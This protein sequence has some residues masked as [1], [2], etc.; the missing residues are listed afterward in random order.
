M[1][2]AGLVFLVLHGHLPWQMPDRKLSASSEQSDFEL[3]ATRK[4]GVK[5]APNKWFKFVPGFALRW[6]RLTRR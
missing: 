5:M 4:F 3:G 2:G 1:V 6:R